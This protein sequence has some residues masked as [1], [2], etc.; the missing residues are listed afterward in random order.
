MNDQQQLSGTI[1][2][3]LFHNQE[4]G[5]SVFVLEINRNN[6]AT[7]CGHF[8]Q[9]RPGEQVS[10]AGSW[11]M[12]PKFGKQFQATQC[13]A[14]VP[15]TI[16]GLKKYLGS[17]LIKGI[18]P[19]FAEKLVKKFGQDVLDVIDEHPHRLN[20]IPGVG[21]KR[22]ESIVH[23]WK[24]QKEISH[25]MVFLQ[26]K[27]I[28]TVYATKIYKKY[29][30]NAIPYLIEN[31]Y[32]LADDIWGIGFKMAD[33]I[34]QNMGFEKNSVKRIRSG[35]LFVLGNQT[36]KG[37]LYTPV[38]ELK[39]LS[40]ELLELKPI[41]EINAKLKTALHDLYNTEKIK[42]ISPEEYHLVA[43][44]PHYYA[45][46]GASTKILQLLEYPS[47][48]S[49]DIDAIYQELRTQKNDRVQL[50]EDQQRGVLSCLQSKVS[51]ITGGP[52][53]GKT[54]LIKKLL[55][56]LDDNKANYKLASPT[57]RAAKRI[58]ESTGRQASTLHRLLEFD[59]ST[60]SFTRNESNALNLDFLIIDEASMLDIF[61]AYALLKA[62][63]LTAHVVFIGDIDQLPSVGAGN[64]LKDLIASKQSTCIRLTQIYRQAQD[65]M[66]VL[67]A[68]RI[69]K[70]EF[71]ISAI[72]GAK[73]DFI[74]IKEDLPENVPVHLK[75]IYNWGL[76]KVGIHK[77]NSMVLVPMHRG[78]VGTQK[79]NVDLQNILNPHDQKKISYA[80]NTFKVGDRIMQVRNNYDKI[81][82]NGD[83]GL[84]KDINLTDKVMHVQFD[85]R[86]I[87]YE[88]S[89]LD[90]LV[91]AY[92]ISIHKSQ[93][94]EYDAVIIPIFT[95]HFTL[96]QRNLIYTAI[97]RAKK[98]CIFIGQTKAIAMA[99]NNNKSVIRK[100]LLKEFLTSDLSA[101]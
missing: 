55:Q 65:S 12:H 3:I 91:L 94:S 11:V 95:Q 93:G 69:N 90:E 47:Q 48:K 33:T 22:I 62:V 88:F 79:L 13:T 31:P 35:L 73:K 68:H 76:K 50:N 38:E 37:H 8:P 45:E 6:T 40:L 17:G 16:L 25:I 41:D 80:A 58:T 74:F 97:T 28:S 54:T 86:M 100:T 32:R 56:V 49:F 30:H 46:K 89:E 64:F 101:R 4:N 75:K 2:R 61:L 15:T 96:L 36:S 60:M 78:S 77:N 72:E 5:Y 92:A 66:I 10:L 29:G 34:A 63:P 24:E 83:T 9:I 87:D 44:T 43:L 59:V 7:I 23:A 57:G 19:V 81:V 85:E 27:G 82:F 67:N 53:T 42:L 99:I 71:P 14:H 20:E 98:F 26:D 84:V 1:E 52:G 18:G 51:V 70:G 21:P 39:Q